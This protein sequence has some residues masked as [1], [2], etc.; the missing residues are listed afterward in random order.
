MDYNEEENKYL[1][2]F[3]S[4]LKKYLDMI[5]DN[6]QMLKQSLYNICENDGKYANHFMQQINEQL[7]IDD[8]I[9]KY[10]FEKEYEQRYQY[11]QFM[12]NQN[13]V[14]TKSRII[15]ANVEILDRIIRDVIS[16]NFDISDEQTQ[17]FG[18]WL[19][20]WFAKFIIEYQKFTQEQMNKV[21]ESFQS[22]E[23]QIKQSKKAYDKKRVK[24]ELSSLRSIIELYYFKQSKIV[25]KFYTQNYC[26]SIPLNNSIK[27]SN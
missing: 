9:S 15:S 2:D 13:I 10:C 3:V 25:Q 14:F 17:N 22:L 27:F 12:C 11:I 8:V 21:A 16:G 26:F 6:Q 1:N 24:S 4:I 19:A 7:K 5:K 20:Q 23:D 18:F